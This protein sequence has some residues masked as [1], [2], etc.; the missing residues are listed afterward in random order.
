[1]HMNS[2]MIARTYVLIVGLSFA[3]ILLV[4]ILG[5]GLGLGLKSKASKDDVNVSSSVW[6]TATIIW[7]STPTANGLTLTTKWSPPTNE[8]STTDG[9]WTPTESSTVTL[10]TTTAAQF[11]DISMTEL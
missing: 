7:T 2:V 4:V 11:S 1:M 9:G 5:L 8:P 3:V 10:S 6:S